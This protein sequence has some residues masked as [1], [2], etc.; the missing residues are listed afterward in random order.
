MALARVIRPTDILHLQY[1]HQPKGLGL[2]AYNSMNS[3]GW[4]IQ[5]R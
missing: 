5:S 4:Y 3:M 2:I 1:L